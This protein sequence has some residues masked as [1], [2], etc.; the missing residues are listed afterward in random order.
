MHDV[1]IA[2]VPVANLGDELTGGP[3][4]EH[5]AEKRAHATLRVARLLALIERP[6]QILRFVRASLHELERS[7]SIRSDRDGIGGTRPFRHWTKIWRGFGRR[8]SVVHGTTRGCELRCFT[9]DVSAKR[10]REL[11]AKPG[12]AKDLDP[13]RLMLRDRRYGW[14]RRRR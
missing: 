5:G 12:C 11:A 10:S 1:R 4:R 14:R 8:T 3:F 9:L 7:P 6:P 2:V 13:K